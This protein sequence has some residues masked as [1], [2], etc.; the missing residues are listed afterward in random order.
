V[1]PRTIAC[2]LV[3][4][5]LA[6]CRSAALDHI[7]IGVPNLDDGIRAFEQATG[8]TPIRGGKHPSH[9]TENALVSLGRGAYLE[10]IAP[11]QDAGTSDD[12]A[13]YLRTLKSPVLIG[14][15]VRVEDVERA[16]TRLQDG[17]YR[18]SAA[19]P[20][21]RITP[22]GQTLEWV[23][24]EVEREPTI[25]TPFFIRWSAATTHP[26]LSSPGGCALREFRLGEPEPGALSRLLASVGARTNVERADR[27]RLDLTLQCGTREA[28][29]AS[30]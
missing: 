3:A 23:A 2:I 16:R 25:T 13:A 19:S 11:Q 17:G 30:E 5:A 7:L 29:F 9:G 21:S 18:A 15:A 1:V 6:G 20:G 26:S 4:L 27:P 22:G 10:L 8:V 24:F 12:F 14:W 28:S